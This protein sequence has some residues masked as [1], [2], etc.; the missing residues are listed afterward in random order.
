MP[1]RCAF[2]TRISFHVSII[3][4]KRDKCYTCNGILL[5]ALS[6]AYKYSC[7]VRSVIFFRG[8]P[9]PLHTVLPERKPTPLPRQRWDIQ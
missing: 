4:K 8:D 1:K 5:V 3:A 7:P 2:A 6:I 9:G